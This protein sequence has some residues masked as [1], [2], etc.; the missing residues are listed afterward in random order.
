MLLATRFNFYKGFD[1]AAFLFCASI[2]SGFAGAIAAA[3]A[4]SVDIS[5]AV[6]L[7]GMGLLGE[8]IFMLMANI[9]MED[10][11]SKE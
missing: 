9:V 3:N 5:L 4:S 6:F 2:F 1:M 10:Q 8:V 11:T 7:A